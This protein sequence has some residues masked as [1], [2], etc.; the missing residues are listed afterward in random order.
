MYLHA[1]QYFLVCMGIQDP[2]GVHAPYMIPVF[3]QRQIIIVSVQIFVR[4][5]VSDKAVSAVQ[6]DTDAVFTMAWRTD[7]LPFYAD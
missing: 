3:Q 6:N 7:D 2:L 1:L 5:Q 4:I